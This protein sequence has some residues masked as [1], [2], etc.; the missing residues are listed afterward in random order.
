[1]TEL[2]ITHFSLLVA[3]LPISQADQHLAEIKTQLKSRVPQSSILSPLL[4]LL[5]N[6]LT[7]T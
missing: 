1:M 3:F 7:L 5:L 2:T 4:V 6:S